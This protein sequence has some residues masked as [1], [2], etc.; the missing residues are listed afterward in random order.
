M[1]YGAGDSM[2][3]CRHLIAFTICL[4]DG[5]TAKSCFEQVVPGDVHCCVVMVCLCCCLHCILSKLKVPYGHI[6]VFCLTLASDTAL[7]WR[8]KRTRS[9]LAAGTVWV[10]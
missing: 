9:C 1:F 8:K 6:S 5:Q 2:P 10:L 3:L 7:C 4:K